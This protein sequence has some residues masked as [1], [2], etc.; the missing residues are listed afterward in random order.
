MRVADR[1]LCQIRE[2]GTRAFLQTSKFSEEKNKELISFSRL[3]SSELKRRGLITYDDMVGLLNELISRK[4]NLLKSFADYD[5]LM[6]DEFQ[7]T[8][9]D[10]YQLI[11]S[12]T[13][14]IGN[15]MVVGDDDQ[16]IYKFRGGDSRFFK[17]LQSDFPESKYIFFENNFRSSNEIC[18]VAKVF[19]ESNSE[20]IPKRV[21]GIGDSGS[22]PTYYKDANTDLL[23]VAVKKLLCSRKASEI[24]IITRNNREAQ[25]VC[26]CLEAAGCPCSTPKDYLKD[27]AV[28]KVIHA[29]LRYYYVPE[30]DLSLMY[31]LKFMGVATFPEKT[32]RTE[33]YDACLRT[34]GNLQTSS[35]MQ[36]IDAAVDLLEKCI[37]ISGSIPKIG[38]YLGL[39]KEHPVY[40]ALST[41]C[42][43]KNISS[44]EQLCSVCEEIVDFQDTVRIGYPPLDNEI[45]VLTAHDSKGLQFDAVIIWRTECFSL[46][47][48]DKNLMY[49]A[50]T[51][52]KRTLIYM[53]SPRSQ[54]G[55]Y[56]ALDQIKNAVN[57]MTWEG[58]A[59]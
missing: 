23:L 25:E 53:E 8:S 49:V 32:N 7:D 12:L 55:N 26:D 37:D 16:S 28:F 2:K 39:P 18:N 47:S 54:Q 24:A 58:G 13:Q 15:L 33:S 46:D 4:P 44:W 29:L 11:K 9:P 35:A 31:L 41:L 20:R 34:S 10:Q 50:S 40:A 6:V 48:E 17:E 22:I 5:Y 27:D 30:D 45:Q 42:A 57:F 51:R 52:A 19:V 14:S 21:V 38:S 59:Q 43:D 3:V 36:R 56:N 1:L